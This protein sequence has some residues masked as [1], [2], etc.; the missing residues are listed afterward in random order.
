MPGRGKVAEPGLQV[1]MPGQR[2]IM[3][4]PVSVCH[5]VSTTGQRPPP[6]WV[7]YQIQAS[8]LMGSPTEPSTRRRDRSWRPGYSVPHFMKVRMAVGAV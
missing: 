6:M 5:Q 2:G 8:G 4:A 1:V 7:E 3:M